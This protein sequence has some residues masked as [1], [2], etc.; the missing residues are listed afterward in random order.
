MKLRF[1]AVI[2]LLTSFI[3]PAVAQDTLT[4]KPKATGTKMADKSPGELVERVGTTGFVQIHAESFRSL[5]PQQKELAYWLTQAAIAI[6]PI[7]Y[8]QLSTY[9][10]RQ[11]RM[12]EEIV[13][14]PEGIDP[15]VAQNITTFAKLFWANRGNHNEMTAQKFLPEVTFEQFQSAA[16]QAQKNG[17]FKFGYADLPA[18]PTP[19]ALN[20]EL[21]ELKPSLFDPNFEPMVTAK[22]PQG[23]KDI[24]QASANSFYGPGVT[25]ADLDKFQ[26]KYP[27]NSNVVKGSDGTLKEQV[28]RA[29]TP[30]G[31]IP[32]GVY[33]VYLK[34]A[35]EYL[36]KAQK[37]ADPQQAEVIGDLIRFYQTGDFNDWLKFGEHWVKND[38]TVDFA[39]GFIEVYRDARGRKGSSQ[40]F[41][42]VTDKALTEAMVKLASNAEYFEA[43]A[44]WDAKYK[45]TNFTP[46]TVKAIETIVETGD[47]HVNTIGDNLPNENEIREKFGTKNFLFT[48]SSRAFDAASGHKMIEEFGATPEIIARNIKYG[49]EAEE[50]HTAMHEVIG[51]GSGKL[52]PKFKGGTEGEL[53]E[54]Y[55]TMEEARAD[56]MSLWNAFD[57]KLKEL[58][59]ISNQEEVAKA[60]YDNQALA[61]LT[62]LRRIPKGTTIEEDHQRNRALISNYLIAKGS[63]KMFDRDGKTYVEVADYKMMHEQVGQLL[64]EIMR[65]KAEGDYAALKALIDKYGVHFDP[66]LR[67]Q[68]VERYKKLNTPAYWAGINAQLNA[69]MANG[70]VQSV[71]MEYPRNVVHQYIYYGS[72]YGKGLKLPAR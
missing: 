45:K 17:G 57:P 2:L 43:H 34:R 62:Q 61:M 50:L 20:K 32:A 15:V 23:G 36:A 38:A 58:G 22:S 71:D 51:H 21:D 41:V 47:F 59:L 52:N 67:D 70:K 56:L 44:P 60:M 72:M 54:Y 18:L 49:Q 9:G 68:V 40:A 64:A 14:R 10:I 6:D 1:S 16:L 39:N 30:D 42:S 69:K 3:I 65:M 66:K 4:A 7:I 13:S 24:I 19:A 11:K 29:G 31:K 5:T 8:G 63:V 27:L 53:K 35:N 48:G 46:P 37:V 55:S 26:D 25:L 12:L 33:A 28:W